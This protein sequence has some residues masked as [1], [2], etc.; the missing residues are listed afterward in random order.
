M[1]CFF[2]EALLPPRGRRGH[3]EVSSEQEPPRPSARGERVQAWM[4]QVRPWRGRKG[5]QPGTPRQHA[6]CK[7]S[8]LGLNR[9]KRKWTHTCQDHVFPRPHCQERFTGRGLDQ[10]L[11][12]KHGA[13]YTPKAFSRGSTSAKRKGSKAR[14]STL[15]PLIRSLGGTCTWETER[16]ST[17]HPKFSAEGVSP[18]A[19]AA[20]TAGPPRASVSASPAAP[21]HWLATS[22]AL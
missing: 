18:N 4:E 2:R 12:G 7:P 19:T 3:P 16:R 10:G 15:Q 21:G 5:S 17:P 22:A 14:P 6:G 8:S 20:D 1:P 9:D 11:M 13:P